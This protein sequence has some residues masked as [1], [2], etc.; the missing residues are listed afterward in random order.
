VRISVITV[1]YNSVKTI[2]DTIESVIGQTYSD[3][4]YI[5]V[6]GGS[7]DGTVAIISSYGTKISRFI[8]E[9]DRG[10]YDAMNKGLKL[11]TGDVAGI[12]NADD[13]FNTDT[14]IA[15]IATEFSNNDI[16][17]LYG[18]VEFIKS[19]KI[20]KIVRY[21]SSKKFNTERFR[22]GFMP[23]HPSF[24]VKREYYEK[25]GYYKVDYKIGADFD[26]LIRFL[27]INKLKYKYLEMPFVTMRTGG[28]SN[29]TL[30]SIFTLNREIVRS[31]RENGISTNYFNIYSKYFIKQ[32]EFMNN[33]VSKK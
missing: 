28:A 10:I 29:K 14:I 21:Y 6:D 15:K 20:G 18:D 31:C 22:Y 26:L 11:S 13:F 19:D 33:S 4:E 2:R 5:I 27:Y 23:A 25:F 30:K 16:D 7:T 24:Y 9:P 8:S 12:L 3:I 1:C 32:F 17:A